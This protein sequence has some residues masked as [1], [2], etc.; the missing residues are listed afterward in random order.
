MAY[1][2]DIGR[3]QWKNIIITG[4]FCAPS[5]WHIMIITFMN[6]EVVSLISLLVPPVLLSNLYVKVDSWCARPSSLAELGVEDWRNLSGQDSDGCSL[7]DIDWDN[8][9]QGVLEN[10][11]S[12]KKRRRNCQ[13]WEFDQTDF[14][15]TITSEFGLVC[16]RDYLTSLAQTLY[17]VGMVLGVLTFG[18]LADI[19]GRK[20]VMVPLLVGMAI[21]GVL[22]SQMP[23]YVTFIICRVLNAFLVIA[24]FESFF[25]YMLE[26]VGGVWSTV[27]G[28]GSMFVWVTGWLSLAGLAYLFRDWRQLMLYSS[29]PSLLSVLMYW[30]LPESPRW[31]VSK[32]RGSA[33]LASITTAAKS[34]NLT[35]PGNVVINKVVEG[36]QQGIASLAQQPKLLFY[37]VNLQE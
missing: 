26:F 33:A 3:W 9:N 20:T 24:I 6:A 11:N 32:G 4:L 35:P 36:E 12:S 10:K 8:Y 16:G 7:Y 22:T 2:G 1:L 14:T 31:L 19:Y 28:L 37:L 18:V 27:I 23:N 29:L 34:N 5:V 30:L 15:S 21:T 13:K 25:T 17:F